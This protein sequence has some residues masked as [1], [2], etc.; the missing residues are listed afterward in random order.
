MAFNQTAGNM[1]QHYVMLAGI[2]IAGAALGYWLKNA[3]AKVLVRSWYGLPAVILAIAICNTNPEVGIW[4][5]LAAIL[6]WVWPIWP[7][8]VIVFAFAAII[9]YA[10]GKGATKNVKM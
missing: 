5:L 3:L 7:L 2:P 1:W 8:L 9:F 4:V 10:L 6:L